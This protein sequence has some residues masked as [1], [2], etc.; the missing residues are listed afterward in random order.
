MI[1]H[2]HILVNISDC[3]YIISIDHIVYYIYL[4]IYINYILYYY[5]SYRFNLAV[6][7]GLFTYGR[8]NSGSVHKDI[9]CSPAPAGHPHSQQ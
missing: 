1:K 6:S 7:P 4:N 3:P 8:K 2:P 9:I 5:V